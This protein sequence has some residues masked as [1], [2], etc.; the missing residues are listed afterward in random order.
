MGA[1]AHDVGGPDVGVVSPTSGERDVD[2]VLREPEVAQE[3]RVHQVDHL[4]PDLQQHLRIGHLRG[5]LQMVGVQVE[6]QFRA[7]PLLLVHGRSVGL[8]VVRRGVVAV[9]RDL[10]EHEPVQLLRAAEGHVPLHVRPVE[11]H[12]TELPA[13]EP[14]RQYRSV[15]AVVF[16]E[17]F[18]EEAGVRVHRGSSRGAPI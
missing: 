8:A 10:A 17:R 14:V 5:T 13:G 15:R 1:Q 12:E 16:P 3:E 11:E 18:Q 2:L 4:R 9:G 7:H 6:D